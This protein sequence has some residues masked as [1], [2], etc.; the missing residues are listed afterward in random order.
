[1][2]TLLIITTFLSCNTMKKTPFDRS[3]N[4][5]FEIRKGEVFEI[6]LVTNA[7]TGFIWEWVNK[8][9]ITIVDSV[10]VRTVDNNP[11][12]YV[13][14]SVDRYWQFKGVEKGTDTLKFEYCR[15]WN[16]E[17]VVRRQTVVVVVK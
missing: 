14:G 1:M 6:K 10:G 11:E 13:G 4:N 15:P 2:L 5:R 17:E 3:T 12:G 7:S 16:K 9:E 8:N